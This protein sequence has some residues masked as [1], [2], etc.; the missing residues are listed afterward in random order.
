M[1]LR[2][3][4]KNFGKNAYFGSDQSES[5]LLK[6]IFFEIKVFYLNQKFLSVGKGDSVLYGDY[7]KAG[8]D[9][10]RF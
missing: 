4:T 7:K 10:T 3:Q 8:A 1:N 2:L 6:P 5:N 9:R